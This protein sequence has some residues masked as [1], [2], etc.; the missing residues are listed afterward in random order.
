MIF[1]PL[2]WIYTLRIASVLLG[3]QQDEKSL[4]LYEPR[5]RP[6]SI[7]PYDPSILN[8]GIELIEIVQGPNL[9]YLEFIFNNTNLLSIYDSLKEI[10]KI[11][12]NNIQY[13]AFA[14]HKII[15]THIIAIIF[16]ETV[17]DT[18]VARE[19]ELSLHKNV[20]VDNK[21][22]FSQFYSFIK[23]SIKHSYLE[24]YSFDVANKFRVKVW[25]AD[26]LLNSKIRVFQ[27]LLEIIGKDGT[28]LFKQTPLKRKRSA[29][30]KASLKHFKDK[31]RYY[32]TI[33]LPKVSSLAESPESIY[34]PDYITPLK[35]V[36]NSPKTFSTMDIETLNV[37]GVQT[38][39][40]ITC[41][42]TSKPKYFI[43]KNLTENGITLLWFDFFN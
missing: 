37:K 29:F 39:F 40:L 32:S 35:R 34:K 15:I 4:V 33:A 6:T 38:P 13:L 41:K 27:G 24:G 12:T 30:S 19:L 9:R 1:F 20:A 2:E 21:T 3:L 36:A 7:I 17:F 42:V 28:T 31:G 18:P 8:R 10:Y 16:D 5:P 22:T 11:L 26:H 43:T 25:K 23:S 14:D